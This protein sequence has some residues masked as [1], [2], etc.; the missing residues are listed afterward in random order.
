MRTAILSDIHGNKT[1][2]SAVLA[3][4]SDCQ[5]IWVLGDNV[6]YYYHPREVMEMLDNF[7]CTHIKGN[8]EHLLAG[9]LNGSIES[10]EIKRK[11]GEGIESAVDTMSKEQLDFLVNL[12]DTKELNHSN[13]RILLAHG[14]PFKNNEYVYPDSVELHEKIFKLKYDFVFLGHT[15]K[16]MIISKGS[17]RIINPG[18]VGQ[19]RDK[20]PYASFAIVDF[21]N[22]NYEI[23][24]VQYDLSELLHEISQR[25]PEL[26]LLKHILLRK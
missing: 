20:N 18:S 13:K 9:V 10:N 14:S 3:Q 21:E 7:D 6:G 19:P 11:Y 17:Q 24:R 22:E 25:D 2:L 16:P 12:P 8:H 4:V 5:Q 23:I 26:P 1:A 15:H